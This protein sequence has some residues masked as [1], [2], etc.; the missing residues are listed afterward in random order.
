MADKYDEAVAYLT[1]RPD[2][3]Y[4]SWLC[5]ESLFQF[6]E[7]IDGNDEKVCGCLTE[8]R[9]SYDICAW[10]DELTAAIRADERLP[11][12]AEDITP[13]HLPVFAEWQRRIDKELGRTP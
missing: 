10:T 4:D 6:V 2:E 3:I 13:A 7:P 8:I 5:A 11:R 9:G 12:N 1:A